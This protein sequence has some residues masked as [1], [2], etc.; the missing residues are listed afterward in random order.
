MEEK[1]LE[2]RIEELEIQA[3][4]LREELKETKS[5]LFHI[6]RTQPK[7]CPHNWIFLSS[8]TEQRFEFG[9]SKTSQ[10]LPKMVRQYQCE[11]CGKEK[12]V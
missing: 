1:E 5:D 10:T 7:L 11:W 6:Y 9:T 12:I 4:I 2:K 3:Q 8:W